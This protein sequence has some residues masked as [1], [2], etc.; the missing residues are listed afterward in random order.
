MMA[1]WRDTGGKPNVG[2]ELP[3]WRKEAGLVVEQQRAIVEVVRPRDFMWRWRAS[4]TRIDLDRLVALGRL[5]RE[6]A[7]ETATDFAR[8]ELMPS[9]RMVTPA[10]MEL[11]GRKPWHLTTCARAAARLTPRP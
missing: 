7:D 5:S 11:I 10:V 2:P 3:R 8:V 1:S 6:R 9:A 4:F